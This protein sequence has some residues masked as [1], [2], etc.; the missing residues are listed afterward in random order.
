M[1]EK[2]K[3]Y[4]EYEYYDKRVIELFTD[5][6]AHHIIGSKLRNMLDL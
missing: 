1:R 4:L 5:K 6:T 2:L 3:N